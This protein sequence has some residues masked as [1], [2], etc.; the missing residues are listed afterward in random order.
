MRS[1]LEL[2]VLHPLIRY[3]KVAPFFFFLSREPCLSR[4]E[5][6]VTAAYVMEEQQTKSL[7]G[8]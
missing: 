3:V 6:D 7:Q 5:G 1:S 4:D 2:A 8:L